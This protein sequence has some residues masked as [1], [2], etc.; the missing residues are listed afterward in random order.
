MDL[1]SS[2]EHLQRQMRQAGMDNE[3]KYDHGS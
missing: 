2:A 3:A 1:K